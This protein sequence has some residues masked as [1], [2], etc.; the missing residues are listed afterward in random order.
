MLRIGAQRQTHVAGVLLV[1]YVLLLLVLTLAPPHYVPPQRFRL[2]PFATIMQQFRKGGSVFLV[3]VPG[4]IVAFVPLGLLVPF[5]A[6]NL[7]SLTRILL[8]GA[9]ISI[10]IELLQLGFTERVADI[11]DVLLNVAG[12][13]LGYGWYQLY[14][15]WLG[16]QPPSNQDA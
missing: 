6:T 1:G 16:Q 12:A 13:A 9:L 7:R 14:V 8:V 3:N 10:G 15:A 5:C 11:D 4:N 2:M